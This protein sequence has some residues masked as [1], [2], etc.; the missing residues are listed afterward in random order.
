LAIEHI[1]LK[2]TP[3]RTK[4]DSKQ[5]NITQISPPFQWLLT[6]NTWEKCI[7]GLFS[8][9]Q[10]DFPRVPPCKHP[11]TIPGESGSVKILGGIEYDYP[12]ILEEHDN[13]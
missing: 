13:L 8:R 11:K 2:S 1:L 5:L 10:N 7:K 3:K 9:Y 6:Q 4:K 12:G